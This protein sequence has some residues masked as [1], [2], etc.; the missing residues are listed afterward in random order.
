MESKETEK[1]RFKEMIHEFYEIGQ[2]AK[3]IKTEVFIVEIKKKLNQI[4]NESH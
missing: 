2:K 4:F 1:V 3:S